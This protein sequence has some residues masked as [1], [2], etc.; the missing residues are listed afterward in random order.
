[1]KELGLDNIRLTRR[2]V[3]AGGGGAMIAL[4]ALGIAPGAPMAS[5]KDARALLAELTGGVPVKKGR[6]HVTLP[7]ITGKGP[8]TRITVSADSP[9]SGDDYVKAIHIVAERNTVPEVASF[10]FTPLNGRAE[11]TTR[12]RLRKTQTIVAVA[13]MNNGTA[14]IGKGRTKVKTGGG[15]C[16]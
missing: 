16:G 12:I 9:M 4:A 13:E 5:P 2:Q 7:K 14:F 15:G 11:V 6:V 8:F 10:Y 1:M 3:L